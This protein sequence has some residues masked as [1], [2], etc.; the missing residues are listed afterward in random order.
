[1]DFGEVLSR[2]WQV[3]WKHKVL[4]IFGILAGCGSTGGGAEENFRITY[5]STAPE[6]E[7][8]FNN[9]FGRVPNWQIALIVGILI[10]ILLVLV[11][12]AIFLGTVGRIGLIQGTRQV[13]QEAEHLIFGELFSG[14]L[15]FFWRVFG[16]NLLVGIAGFVLA[17]IIIIPLVIF[18]VV[19]LGLGLLCIIPLICVLI[20]LA[21][22]VG[23][24]I[25]QANIAIV[26]EDLGIIAGLQRGW[27]IFRSN[28][29]TM[30][31]MALILYLGVGLIGGFLIG[32]P[33]ALVAAPFLTGLLV[34]TNQA[35]GGGLLLS[36]LCFVVYLPILIILNG[37][38]KGYIESA[39]TLTYLR[40]RFKPFQEPQPLP[41]SA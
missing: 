11:I 28:L 39:W 23:V 7:R 40:L 26:I 22:L 30:I 4:W 14:S 15:P 3:I 38:L 18:A 25:E 36:A 27:E 32:L 41:E 21:W 17:L 6:I 8:Y 24:I 10:L 35:V 31:V 5:R 16:L 13:D 34:N 1:M 20:P 33:L 12:L 2:A 37:V 9:F 29:G 19:T